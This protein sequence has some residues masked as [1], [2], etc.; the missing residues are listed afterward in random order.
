[1]R[2]RGISA[3]TL[4]LLL[5][6][7]VAFWL[8]LGALTVAGAAARSRIGILPS[9]GWLFVL[10]AAAFFGA[11][12]VAASGR[13]ARVAALSIVAVLPWLPFQVP[14]ATFVWTGHARAW[15]WIGV[16]V[17]LLAP[18]RRWIIP[19]TIRRMAADRRAAPWLAAS[20][21]LCVY[22]VAAWLVSPR[23][24]GGDEPHYLIITQSLLAD[25]DL[26]IENNHR[27][28]DYRAYFDGVLRPDY[29]RRGQDG[30]IYSIHAPGLPVIIAPA[31]ALFGYPGVVVFVTILSAWGTALAWIAS[32]RATADAA[33]AWFGWAAAALS[34]PFMF[35]SFVIYPDAPAALAVMFCVVTIMAGRETSNRSLFATGIALALLPWLHTRFAIL[36]AALGAVAAVRTIGAKPFARRLALLL[37]PPAISAAAWLWFFFA[38]YG[39]PNPA[40]AYGGATQTSLANLPRGLVGFLFDQQFGLLPNAPVYACAACGFVLMMR[41]HR[42]LTIELLLVAAPYGLAVVLYQMW[43]AGASSPARFLVAILLPAAIP[44][45]VWFSVVGRGARILGLGALLVSV[46]ITATV[47][48]VERGQLLYNVRQEEAARWLTWISPVVNIA[49]GVPSLFHSSTGVALLHAVV[50]VIACAATAWIAVRLGRSRV[51]SGTVALGIGVAAAASMMIALSVVW[52]IDRAQPVT[53]QAGNLALLRHYDRAR[54]AVR[55]EPLEVLP[56]ADVPPLLPLEGSPAGVPARGQPMVVLPHAPAALY[57][58]DADVLSRGAGRLVATSD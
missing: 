5:G 8:S 55:F 11:T 41:R 31:F 15:L 9:I 19:P 56:L 3:P 50:W 47:A 23:L 1:M 13:R 27:Q 16:L 46:L 39:T 28:R 37:L 54:L 4:A 25:R 38:I 34:V 43:W 36:A 17:A 18:A 51:D 35:H 26:K 52:R 44:A 33:S 10:I 6:V 7:A 29:L 2:S 21:A 45:A 32:W 58:I 22:L 48:G 12:G 53:P 49:T 42:R 24:P 30:Q 57:Q 20:F 14:V 40:A